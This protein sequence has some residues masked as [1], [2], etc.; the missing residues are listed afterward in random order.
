[1]NRLGCL[2]LLAVLLAGS[3]AAETFRTIVGGRLSVSADRTDSAVL[4]LTYIDSALIDLAGDKR[5]LKGVELE[6]R[7]PQPFMKYRGSIALAFYAPLKPIPAEGVADISAD[8]LGFEL[9]PNK[10]QAVYH[11]PVRRNHGLKASPYV[12]MPTSIIPVTS[13]PLLVRL[14]PVIKGLPEEL[15]SISFQLSAKAIPADEGALRVSFK[16]PEKLKDKP[17]TLLIDDVVV[18]ERTRELILPAGEHSVVVVSDH[19]RNENRRVIIER[20]KTT[21]LQLELQDPT[22]L[23]ILEAPENAVVFF[24]GKQVTDTR[25]P[26]A[27]DPGEH[28]I[29]FTIGDYSVVRPVTVRKGRTYRV[30]LSI[31]VDISESD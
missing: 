13:F 4:P 19:Y 29:R 26:F 5:F 24:D 8:R 11:I 31:D 17:F 12:S 18:E 15:E 14:M 16:Y 30:S 25:E 28:E 27:A 6:L 21:D 1:M 20:A 3:A 7:I 10:L 23:L 9:I 22:P 2:F